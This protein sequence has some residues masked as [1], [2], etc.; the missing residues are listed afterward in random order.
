MNPTKEK[1]CA[2]FMTLRTYG[3]WL[4]GD[5]RTSVDRVRN[6][7]NTS[8]IQPDKKLHHAMQTLQKQESIILNRQQGDIVLDGM[9]HACNKYNWRLYALHIRSNHAHVTVKSE[10]TPE[11]VMTQLKAHA[12]RFLRKQNEFPQEQKIWSR[13][14]ST[15]YLWQP[16]SL[17]FANEYTI[18]RQGQKMAYIFDD[19]TYE[20]D[21]LC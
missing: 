13:H 19:I 11:H 4:H 12:T 17:Y 18:E 5:D 20:E 2:Y 8:R 3:T 21:F 6:I 15:K 16:E 1:P 10:R 14:G 9:T 7:V